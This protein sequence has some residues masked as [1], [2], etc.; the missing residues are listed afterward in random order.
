MQGFL[1]KIEE[2]IRIPQKLTLHKYDKNIRN[3]YLFI[4]ENKNFL[5]V[6]VK[7]LNGKGFVITI[8]IVENIQ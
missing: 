6:I 4:K 1:R 7:Y 3:Y 2:T 8:S 5:K